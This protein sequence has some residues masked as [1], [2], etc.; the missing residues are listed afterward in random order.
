M[1]IN[2]SFLVAQENT[3]KNATSTEKII[4][5]SDL[6]KKANDI[7]REGR[8]L[9][10]KLKALSNV[11]ELEKS[12]SELKN[13]LS[14]YKQQF[15]E[16]KEAG[17][18]DVENLVILR[19]NMR[20]FLG[21]LIKLENTVVER[22]KGIETLKE[23]W[24][25]KNEQWQ[26]LQ[27][28][29][30]L[31]SNNTSRDILKETAEIIY[32]NINK[33]DGIDSNVL[34]AKQSISELNKEADR[35]ADELDTQLELLRN[36]LFKKSGSSMLSGRYFIEFNEKF[37]K[38]F[39]T[40]LENL[41]RVKGGYFDANIWI[42]VIQIIF[43]I[44][45]AYYF[46]KAENK[47]LTYI[48]LDF[49]HKSYIASGLIVGVSLGIF[50]L[51]SFPPIV[52]AAYNIIFGAAFCFIFCNK[53]EKPREKAGIIGI[54]AVFIIYRLM[55]I[56]NLPMA[57]SRLIL[58]IVALLAA[59]YFY[60]LNNMAFSAENNETDSKTSN[61]FKEIEIFSLK[62]KF[63]NI[64]ISGFMIASFFTQL[65]G[66]AALAIRILEIITKSVLIGLVGRVVLRLLKGGARLLLNNHLMI[67]LA[68]LI[69]FEPELIIKKC[70]VIITI[71]VAYFSFAAI[72]SVWGVYDNLWHAS[73]SIMDFGFTM[74]NTRFT[75]ENIVWAV[76]VFYIIIFI[77]W[78]VRTLLETKFYP[79]KNIEKGAGISINLLIYYSF[80]ILA[81]TLSI[82]ILGI[83]FQNLLVVIGALGVGIGF[84]LQNIVNN[85][86]SG[87]IL[88]FE[89]SIKVGDIVVINGTWGSV[90]HMGLRATIVQTFANAEMIVPNSDLVASTVNNWTMTNRKTRFTVSVGVAYGSDP[91][92][93]KE[94]LLD[95]AKNQKNV[96]KDPAPSVMFTTFGENGMNFDLRCWVENIDNH[97]SSQDAV[98][99]EIV[100]QFKANGITIPFP[101]RD[102]H[103]KSMPEIGVKK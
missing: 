70:N 101:Q 27:K 55:N 69:T 32:T 86:A 102:L 37:K 30:N 61:E 41:V 9:E 12:I 8:S 96:L 46:K 100:K 34:R 23:D 47:T 98:M 24:E 68:K 54:F 13:S 25:S 93:V 11:S 48:G 14:T 95:I 52:K 33:F 57:L 80:I 84:G 44:I 91:E 85:F 16:T 10:P 19:S 22:L 29:Q 15:E 18:I 43:A 71:L 94:V 81:I 21:R 73:A 82:G 72:L 88:L 75:L 78:V 49:L 5:V 99:Y 66:Y 64:I 58:A 42:F 79:Q 60:K 39:S 90:K 2:A 38:D 3:E 77:S 63:L 40:A 28:Q 26:V 36:Y 53:F 89:R 7:D 83:S 56:I 59:I 6:Y 35:I 1:A 76:V 20:L 17:N 45:F 74:Q 92:K 51:N 67:G 87:L 103:I 65:A 4:N 97:W 50:L 31:I 62:Q